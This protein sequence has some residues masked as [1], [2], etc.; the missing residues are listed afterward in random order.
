MVDGLCGT[1][2]DGL[3]LLRRSKESGSTRTPSAA[4]SERLALV[5]TVRINGVCPERDKC[6]T[7]DPGS[8]DCAGCLAAWAALDALAVT[9]CP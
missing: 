4:E 6:S 9:R 3:M 5:E 7:F 8:T 1:C 2:I